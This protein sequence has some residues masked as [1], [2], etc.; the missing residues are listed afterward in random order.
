[1]R[2]AAAILSRC[3][4]SPRA[5]PLVPVAAVGALLVLFGFLAC[6]VDLDGAKV[7]KPPFT[8]MAGYPHDI[9]YADAGLIAEAVLWWLC[10]SFVLWTASLVT[11]A[12]CWLQVDRATRHD[13]LLGH[14]ARAWMM[15]PVLMG[16]GVVDYVLI[17]GRM[18]QMSFSHLITNLG[19]VSSGFLQLAELN[20]ALVVVVGVAIVLGMSSLLAEGAHGGRP[21][22]QARATTMLAYAGAAFLFVWIASATSMYRLASTLLC[23]ELRGPTLKLA[24]TISLIVGL[25]L[26]ALLAAAYLSSFAWLQRCH[27]RLVLA[28]RIDASTSSETASPTAFLAAHWPKIV[29]I[30]VPLLPGAAGSLLQALAQA[31]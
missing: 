27:E 12:L 7:P 13:P 8:L 6:I 11:I 24:P 16:V 29:A 25:M 10:L 14:R 5:A 23:E 18:K 17:I 2:S 21:L 15:V 3:A 9:S 20:G 4:A 19:E 30:L 31:H 28:G 26:S 22:Q 1:M